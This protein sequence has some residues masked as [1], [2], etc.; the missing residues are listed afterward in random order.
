M[1]VLWIIAIG[2]HPK[3]IGLKKIILVE[4]FSIPAPSAGET[5]GMIIAIF[6]HPAMHDCRKTLR[7]YVVAKIVT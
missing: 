1:F 7:V 4:I 6:K 5:E 2:Q 3:H